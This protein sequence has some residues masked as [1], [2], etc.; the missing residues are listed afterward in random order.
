MSNHVTDVHLAVISAA[1]PTAGASTNDNI[2][3]IL[4]SSTFIA[5]AAESM[6]ADLRAKAGPLMSLIMLVLVNFILMMTSSCCQISNLQMRLTGKIQ[7]NV[8]ILKQ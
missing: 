3:T 6:E 8:E 5:T 7:M 2:G 1:A 4:S